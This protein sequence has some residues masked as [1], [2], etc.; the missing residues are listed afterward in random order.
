MDI[1]PTTA[2]HVTSWA[3]CGPGAQ[4]SCRETDT[5]KVVS[6]NDTQVTLQVTAVSYTDDTGA[7]V[8]NPTAPA[9][10]DEMRLDWQAPGLLKTTILHGFPGWVGGNPYWCGTGISQANLRLCGA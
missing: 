8:P 7:S 1:T 4:R 5:L 10:G 3:P 2:T 6:G 9:V